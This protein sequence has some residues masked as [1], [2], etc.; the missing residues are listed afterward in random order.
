M[1]N[2]RDRRQLAMRLFVELVTSHEANQELLDGAEPGEFHEQ[3]ANR[4]I[5]AACTFFDVVDTRSP[6]P[7]NTERD[8][9]AVS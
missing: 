8:L 3:C 2:E 5:A 6:I 4:A 9:L 1:S 7:D